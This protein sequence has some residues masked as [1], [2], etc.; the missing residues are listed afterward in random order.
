MVEDSL[1]LEEAEGSQGK[2]LRAWKK[3]GL[4]VAFFPL[5]ARSGRARTRWSCEIAGGVE[6]G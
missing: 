6:G 2:T 1:P 5:L 3:G 4:R